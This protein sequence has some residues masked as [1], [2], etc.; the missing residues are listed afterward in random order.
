MAVVLIPRAQRYLALAADAKP[1]AA[2]AGSKLLETD[3]GEVYVFDG[4][5]WT[6]LSGAR[7]WP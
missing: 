6:R 4:A 7:P 2:L 3:T 1:A 5:A